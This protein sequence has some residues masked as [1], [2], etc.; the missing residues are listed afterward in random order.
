[1]SNYDST[2]DRALPFDRDSAPAHTAGA[3][4]TIAQTLVRFVLTMTLLVGLSASFAW[5]IG[6]MLR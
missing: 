3:S 1:M 6:A 4:F 5:Q 2:F